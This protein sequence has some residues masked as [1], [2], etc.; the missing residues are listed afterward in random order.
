M[1]ITDTISVN[2]G[3]TTLGHAEKTSESIFRSP[4]LGVED[5][6]SLSISKVLFPSSIA[7]TT[8]FRKYS[9]ALRT[10]FATILLVTGLNIFSG[11]PSGV[12][13]AYAIC[14]LSFGAFLALGFLTRPLMAAAAVYYCIAGA[15]SIRHGMIDM[16]TFALMFGSAIFMITGAGKYSVDTII[17]KWI[18]HNNIKAENKRRENMMSYKAFHNIL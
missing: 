16:N 9:V 8:E 18:R 7:G 5:S 14:T 11:G 1:K 3:K 4:V 17:R 2:P 12:A 13:L 10:I 15:L 6:S